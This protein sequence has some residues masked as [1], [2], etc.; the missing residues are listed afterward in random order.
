M[1]EK[2]LNYY[3]GAERYNCAQA[4]LKSTEKHQDVDDALLAEFKSYGGGRAEDGL[5]GALFAAKHSVN[6]E[7]FKHEAR[8]FFTKNA[9][10]IKC[11]EIRKNGKMSCKDCVAAA[12][13][14][15]DAQLNNNE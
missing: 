5:C 7:S 12:A 14:L 15:A 11:K 3:H 1:K 8:A 9:G 6:D 10:S 4:V 2:A 13:E